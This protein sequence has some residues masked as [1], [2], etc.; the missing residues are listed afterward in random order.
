MK[1]GKRRRRALVRL[2]HALLQDKF[3][4]WFAKLPGR[5]G[6]KYHKVFP[7]AW[8]QWHKLGCP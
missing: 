6:V 2:R 4:R 7:C 3:C 8:H 5:L 1:L